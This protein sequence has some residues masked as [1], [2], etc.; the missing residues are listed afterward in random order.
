LIT[1]FAQLGT[2]SLT[3]QAIELA[4]GTAFV[5]VTA[6]ALSLDLR[7]GRRSVSLWLAR[8][9]IIP[10]ACASLIFIAVALGAAALPPPGNAPALVLT[11]AAL[12]NAAILSYLVVVLARA[13]FYRDPALLTGE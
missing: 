7:A 5:L 1:F 10:S 4:L 6:V 13:G 2:R 3:L 8:L 12:V 9:L 11:P